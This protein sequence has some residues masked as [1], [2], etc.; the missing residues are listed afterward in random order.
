MGLTTAQETIYQALRARSAS[1]QA[2]PLTEDD[3][4]YIVRRTA[5]DL[6]VLEQ[7]STVAGEVPDFFEMTETPLSESPQS[8]RVQYEELVSTVVDADTYVACLGAMLKGRAKYRRI[9]ETQ[10]FAH[11]DQVGPRGLLQYGEVET[12]ALAALLVWRKWIYDIDNRAAQDTG[13]F[14][15]P[16]LAGAIGGVPAPA[17]RSPVKRASNPAKGRQVDCIKDTTA[18]EFKLRIT[19]AASGQG[20]WSEELDFATDCRESGYK[21]VLLVLDP[22]ISTKLTELTKAFEAADGECYTGQDAWDHLKAE[23]SDVMVQFIETY[24]EAP[25]KQLYEARA[26]DDGRLPPFELNDD[27]D[28]IRFRIGDTTWSVD[29]PDA[30]LDLADHDPVRDDAGDLLPGM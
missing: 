8:A 28:A 18:Y 13:Y 4:A 12:P 15:E 17:K 7:L 30:D 9:L 25:L 11:M 23:A 20:R 24:V 19:I 5:S 27:G 6:G 2:V 14:I 26:V 3:I 22:T 29:R 10:P 21:P 16:I 1:K